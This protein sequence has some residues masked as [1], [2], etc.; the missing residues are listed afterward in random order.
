MGVTSVPLHLR[1]LG[2]AFR[3]AFRV[4]AVGGFGLSAYL[5]LAGAEGLPGCDATA[6][7][8]CGAVLGTPWS[9]W[10]GL[11]VGLGGAALFLM[12]LMATAG[13][14][15][16]PTPL[17]WSLL[18]GLATAAL[19][20]ALW[21]TG[22]QFIEVKALCPYCMAVH[23]CSTLAA[24][25]IFARAPVYG[26]GGSAPSESRLAPLPLWVS[27]AGL[28][29]GLLA[30]SVIPAG[31]LVGGYEIRIELVKTGALD[32]SKEEESIGAGPEAA[33]PRMAPVPRDVPPPPPPREAAANDGR[34]LPVSSIDMGRPEPRPVRLL[35][36]KLEMT[37]GEYPM[38]GDPEAPHVLAMIT[39]ATCPACRK[40]HGDL[41][42]AMERYEGRF[43]VVLFPM[44]LDQKCNPHL[45]RTGY[46]H[47][48]AC[49]LSSMS[50]ALWNADPRAFAA[51]DEAV[52]RTQ[53]PPEAPE[54]IAWGRDL[55][56]AERFEAAMN[57]ELYRKM[58][59]FSIELF[60]SP[61]VDEKV[62][63][64]LLGPKEA[65]LGNPDSV[66]ELHAWIEE[67]FGWN[68]P[69][70]GEIAPER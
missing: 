8:G 60:Y 10:F 24:A 3:W 43:A 52:F 32:S 6:V 62:L 16:R 65:K 46:G 23:A 61:L 40:M 48:N 25:M 26:A 11:P 70:N 57:E 47:R 41:E 29:L 27:A 49:L 1:T 13:M 63:P 28:G 20:S 64:V 45:T 56:G 42:R 69:Q 5:T 66:E 67:Q 4:V 58:L 55:L 38:I 15:R 22:L 35:G 7:D 2:P 19:G 36:G 18:L 68:D 53:F 9:R 59:S 39:D 51:F 33:R 21:F 12:L 37:L 54:A 14:G 34:A 30:F 31:Q 44:A 50:L 17:R